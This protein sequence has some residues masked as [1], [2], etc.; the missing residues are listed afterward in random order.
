MEGL[1]LKMESQKDKVDVYI[2]DHIERSTEN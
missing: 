2:I 1:G